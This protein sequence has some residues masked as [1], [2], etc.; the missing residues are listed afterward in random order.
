MTS[1]P[2]E[3]VKP[4]QAPQGGQESSSFRDFPPPQLPENQVA[5]STEL[6]DFAASFAPIRAEYEAKG[7]ALFGRIAST[8]ED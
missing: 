7:S 8:V 6:P 2:I 4:V 5:Q 1:E 3:N